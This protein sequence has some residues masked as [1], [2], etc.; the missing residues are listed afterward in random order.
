V[1]GAGGA[2]Q[3]KFYVS[4]GEELLPGNPVTFSDKLDVYDPATDMWTSL[5]PMPTARHNVAGAV[6]SDRLY[7]LGGDDNFTVFSL[8]EA[9]DPTTDNWTTKASMLT[10]R[11]RLA[12][13]VIRTASGDLRLLAVGG[14]DNGTFGALQTVEAYTP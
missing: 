8:V 5:S 3:G 14:G 13:G 4:G 11:Q 7:I 12:A 10:G 6:L 2:I 1:L 9:Y